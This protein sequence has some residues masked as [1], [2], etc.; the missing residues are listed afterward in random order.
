[1]ST[2]NC[3]FKLAPGK[4]ISLHGLAHVYTNANLTD[5]AALDI[6]KRAP[7]VIGWFT[8]YPPDWEQQAEARYKSVMKKHLSDSTTTDNSPSAP[9]AAP[10]KFDNKEFNLPEMKLAHLKE[11]SMDVLKKMCAQLEIVVPENAS[12][13]KLIEL[14]SAKIG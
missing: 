9:S 7:R 14:L 6:L 10:V 13:K 8:E 11:K 1:M 12:K 2:K 3:Q 5:D 4:V